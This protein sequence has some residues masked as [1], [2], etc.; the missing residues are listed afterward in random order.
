MDHGDRARPPKTSTGAG[1]S[2]QTITHRG[3]VYGI[4]ALESC[5]QLAQELRRTGKKWHHHVLS[6]GCVYNPYPVGYA[7]VIEDHAGSV[8]HIAPSDGF[9]TVDKD[10]V[11][12]LHGD[13]ILDEAKVLANPDAMTAALLRV[14]AELDAKGAA[15]HHHMHFPACVLSPHKG[16]WSIAIESAGRAVYETYDEEPVE[17]LRAIEV[18][19]FRNLERIKRRHDL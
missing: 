11:R 5:L 2:P 10:L 1:A 9:P 12:L 16:K 8:A 4:V 3:V 7:L 19:Y 17:T 13:D 6:P 18:S 15:W 14:V